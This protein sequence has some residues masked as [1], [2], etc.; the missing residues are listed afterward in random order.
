LL[1]PALPSAQ[2]DVAPPDQVGDL[3]RR[4]DPAAVADQERPGPQPAAQDATPNPHKVLAVKRKYFPR[5]RGAALFLTP[6]LRGPSSGG[7]GT[8]S[9]TRL[10]IGGRRDSWPQ[11]RGRAAPNTHADSGGPAPAGPGGCAGD[12]APAGPDT[13][14]CPAPWPFE[15][16]RAHLRQG[17]GQLGSAHGRGGSSGDR[18]SSW[19]RSGGGRVDLGW[20]FGTKPV[21]TETATR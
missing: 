16:R 7:E 19:R 21:L 4:L 1:P 9:A 10:A 6:F 5:P 2:G 17:R 12:Q 8:A 3:S 18:S 20:C 15:D 13:R 11:G 14:S